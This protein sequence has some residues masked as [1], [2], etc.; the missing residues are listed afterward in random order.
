M[1][2]P[3][4][5]P[6]AGRGL[7]RVRAQADQL[8]DAA[9]RA[10][11]LFDID[12]AL[13]PNGNSGLL[14]TSLTS[15]ERYQTGRG[16]NTAWTWEHQALTRA[17]WCAGW[18][19]L[20]A[21]FDAVRTSVLCSPRDPVALRAEI[22]A[23]RDKVRHAASGARARFDVKHSAGGMMDAEFAVQYL[24]LAHGRDP[25]GLLEDVGNIALLQRAESAGCCRWASG[26]RRPM[27]IASSAA[28]APRAAR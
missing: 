13:R 19:P 27:P 10:G 15:F 12:T 8:A 20:A 1:T 4:S 28:P 25:R 24:V 23:M 17:R 14:V 7:R 6:D 18:Q 11:E 22:V 2:T 16:S 21:R 9:H 26:Q 5:R 3:T